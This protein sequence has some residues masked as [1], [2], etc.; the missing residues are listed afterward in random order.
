MEWNG[1]ETCAAG[2]ER[3]VRLGEQGGPLPSARAV[4]VKERYPHD[5]IVTSHAMPRHGLRHLSGDVA[6]W[7]SSSVYV[8]RLV[9]W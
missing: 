9:D 1:K 8:G 5:I 7:P 2:R 4:E 3:G 6:K